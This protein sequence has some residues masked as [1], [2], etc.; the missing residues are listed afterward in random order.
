MTCARC[1]LRWKPS[2]ALLSGRNRHSDTTAIYREL[3][4]DV[5]G[6]NQDINN[7]SH[8][9]T[10]F[11]GVLLALLGPAAVRALP[12]VPPS[13]SRPWLASGVPT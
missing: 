11:C 9:V 4:A 10:K 3:Y 13:S 8:G 1:R 5:A 2:D 12:L 7:I 6:F